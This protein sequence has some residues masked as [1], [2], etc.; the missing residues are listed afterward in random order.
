MAATEVKVPDIGDFDDVPV[1]EVHVKDGDRVNEEDP[2]ITLESDKATMDVPAPMAGMVSGVRVNVGDRVST[3]SPVMSIDPGDGALAQ[4]PSLVEQQEPPVAA[5]A[6]APAVGPASAVGPAPAGGVADFAG[7][8]AGAGVRRLA[9]ELDVDL[10]KV[11][12]SGPKGRITK[13]DLLGFVR[14]PAP[15]VA[16]PA[17]AAGTGIPE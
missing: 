8:H 17:A 12:G 4:P 2:L 3:G 6:P 1:I 16:T 11:T 14:G 10:A 5:V 13:E 7:S 9:R 15:A